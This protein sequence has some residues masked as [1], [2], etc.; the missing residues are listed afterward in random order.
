M[1][2]LPL[3][4]I[5]ILLQPEFDRK[6]DFQYR[7]ADWFHSFANADFA[8]FSRQAS[9]FNNGIL[10]VINN[11]RIVKLLRKKYFLGLVTLGETNTSIRY[12]G[13]VMIAMKQI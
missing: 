12:K 11:G 13:K 9:P 6:I 7:A 3:E 4:N 5:Q 2:L 8:L 1:N 10:T